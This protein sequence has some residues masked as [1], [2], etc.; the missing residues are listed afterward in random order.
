MLTTAALML[1]SIGASSEGLP[2]ALG[3]DPL[4]RM[5]LSKTAQINGGVV[6]AARTLS[7]HSIPLEGPG[8]AALAPLAPA[9]GLVKVLAK[10][11]P[12]KPARAAAEQLRRVSGRAKNWR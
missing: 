3:G 4:T 9:P 5:I 8:S 2:E 12:E 7:G 6:C 1:V 11:K 10:S